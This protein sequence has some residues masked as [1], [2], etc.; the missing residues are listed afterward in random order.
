[1]LPEGR[2]RTPRARVPSCS[3]C[4]IPPKSEALHRTKPS[5]KPSPGPCYA[6]MQVGP[7]SESA[8]ALMESLFVNGSRIATPLRSSLPGREEA[9]GSGEVVYGV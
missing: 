7:K 3:S 6:C 1:M 8:A 5:P 2:G 4:L 9:Q